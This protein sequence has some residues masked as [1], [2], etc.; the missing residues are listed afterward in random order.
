MI[1][2]LISADAGLALLYDDGELRS[3]HVGAR[4]GSVPSEL[5]EVRYFIVEADDI[6]LVQATNEEEIDT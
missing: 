2:A 3:M 1:N 5:S 6:Q 4:E